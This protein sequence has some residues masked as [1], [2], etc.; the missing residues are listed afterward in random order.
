MGDYYQVS[1]RRYSLAKTDVIAIHDIDGLFKH[2]LLSVTKIDSH[3]GR[4]NKKADI[5]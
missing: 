5:A 4:F 2:H 1:G 3:Q